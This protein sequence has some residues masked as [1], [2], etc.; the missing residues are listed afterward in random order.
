MSSSST[1]VSN[2][3]GMIGKLAADIDAVVIANNEPEPIDTS[4]SRAQLNQL[5]EILSNEVDAKLVNPITRGDIAAARVAPA[6]PSR[7]I[8]GPSSEE[9]VCLSIYLS[10]EQ[11]LR[12][13]PP[14]TCML[15]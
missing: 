7:S 15:L 12:T 6:V 8:D 5:A 4:S 1:D 11:Y 14:S 2:G 13:N 10:A 3:G 9:K